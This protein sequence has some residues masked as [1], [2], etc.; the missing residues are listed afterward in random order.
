M[1]DT[2]PRFC[3]G[4]GA[5]VAPGGRFCG[6]CG[7]RLEPIEAPVGA[8]TGGQTNGTAGSEGCPGYGPAGSF[9]GAE[10][11]RGSGTA[12]ASTGIAGGS[13]SGYSP[14]AGP[15]Y[16]GGTYPAGAEAVGAL[17]PIPTPTRLRSLWVVGALTA[18]TFGLYLLVWFGQTWAELK[19]GRH[20]PKM[21]PVWHGLSLLVPFYSWFQVK[22]H[23]EVINEARRDL[24]GSPRPDPGLMMGVLIVSNVV[25]FISNRVPDGAAIL[26]ALIAA[27]LLAY[28]GV[29]GQ[30]S[31]N[32]YWQRAAGRR[33]PEQVHPGEWIGL[34][35][36]AFVT[37][38]SLMG[39]FGW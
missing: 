15:G 14:A 18:L 7:A 12:G 37:M 21:E 31:L 6:R 3:P 11:A 27:G 24:G 33:L 29:E 9:G 30:A 28:I 1:S 25:G 8:A 5:L 4:C 2:G 39:A 34:G 26:C 20:D 38:L 22:R 23:F 36:G 10:A 35:V 17:P 13:V 32:Q 19:R 16:A